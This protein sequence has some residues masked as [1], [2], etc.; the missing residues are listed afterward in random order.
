MNDAA[1]LSSRARQGERKREDS[2]RVS[3][4]ESGAPFHSLSAAGRERR[5]MGTESA[6]DAAIGR[7]SEKAREEEKRNERSPGSLCRV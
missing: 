3:A 2:A 7:A 6:V 1:G 4:S 5:T